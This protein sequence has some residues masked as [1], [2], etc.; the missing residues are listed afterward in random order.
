MLPIR[1]D[2]GGGVRR[3][4]PDFSGEAGAIQGDARD[5]A[6]NLAH[7]VERLTQVASDLGFARL[8]IASPGPF[9][10]GP[11][12]EFLERKYHGN[13]QYLAERGADASLLRRDPRSVF[14]QVASVICVALPYA[15]PIPLKSRRDGRELTPPP[16]FG[17]GLHGRVARYAQGPDYHL[18]VKEKLLLLADALA[19]ELKSEIVARAC[20]DT[21]PLLERELAER[22]GMSFT[23]KNTLAISPGI[24]S[25]FVLG[26]LLVD[27]KLPFREPSPLAGDGAPLAGCGTC[28]SCLVACPTGA[29]VGEYLL[30]ARRCISYLTIESAED[31]PRDLRS[32]MGGWVYGCDLCQAVCPFNHGGSQKRTPEDLAPFP[33]LVAPELVELLTLTSG[34]YRRLVKGTALRRASRT[35]LARNAAVALGNSG[36]DA[37]IPPLLHA[38]RLHPSPQVREHALWALGRLGWDFGHLSARQAVLEWV[39]S[40]EPA[41]AREAGLWAAMD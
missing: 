30:D 36:K 34:A 3:H 15:A 9:D 11:F 13:M 10:T 20:V 28:S 31:I 24:G 38:L 2:L 39:S 40:S 18:V 33:R 35:M 16:D 26:E 17:E 4:R 1:S 6:D 41:L 19:S 5:L 21:A 32:Q 12:E 23:G 7:V 29:F 8:S 37:A 14:E 25:H 27:V 22:A